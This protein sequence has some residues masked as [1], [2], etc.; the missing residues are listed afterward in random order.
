MRSEEEGKEGGNRCIGMLVAPSTGDFR[1]SPY[2]PL[3]Q[4]TLNRSLQ[5][6]HLGYVNLVVL[7]IPFGNVL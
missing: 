7:H 1:S 3:S 2:I 5:L 6:A 4:C